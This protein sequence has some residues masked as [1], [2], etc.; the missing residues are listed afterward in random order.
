[1]KGVQ[2]QLEEETGGFAPVNVKNVEELETHSNTLYKRHVDDDVTNRSDRSKPGEV[3][4]DSLLV[5]HFYM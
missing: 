3:C 2:L 4:K 1:M 5:P